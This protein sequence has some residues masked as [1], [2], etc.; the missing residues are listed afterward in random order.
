MTIA[1]QPAKTKANVPIA[2]AANARI[3]LNPIARTVADQNAGA[4]VGE[5]LGV[6]NCPLA[7][8]DDVN[9]LSAIY[10]NRPKRFDR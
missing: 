8:D 6:V 7:W 4:M 10:S 2:S 1:P 3:W 5:L 9:R